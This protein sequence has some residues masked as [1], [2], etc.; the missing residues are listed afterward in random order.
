MDAKNQSWERFIRRTQIFRTEQASRDA[1]ASTETTSKTSELEPPRKRLCKEDEEQVVQQ[2]FK[3]I[4]AKGTLTRS[5][6]TKE[7]KL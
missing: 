1:P 6:S 5:A 2:V 4:R 7:E 3:K